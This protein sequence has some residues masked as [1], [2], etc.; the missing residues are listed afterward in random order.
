MRKI[1]TNLVEVFVFWSLCALVAGGL[2]RR[3]FLFDLASHFRV[4]AI[5][6]LL[7]GG[8]LLTRFKRP[9]WARVGLIAGTLGTLTLLPYLVPARVNSA[10]PI[11]P[12]RVMT[13]NVLTSNTEY[14]Q[15]IQTIR[16][17]SPDILVLLETSR[18]W[19]E[20]LEA[21]LSADWPYHISRPANDNFGI[22]LFSR[23]PWTVCEIDSHSEATDVDS[24]DARF[25]ELGLRV[26][27]THPLPPMNTVFWQD[28]AAVFDSIAKSITNSTEGA[29]LKTVVVGDLNCTP[30]SPCFTR[31]LAQSGLRD[32][33]RGRGIAPTWSPLFLWM[34]LPIDHAL[35]S[36]NVEV[37]R[38]IVGG[39]IG[40]DHRPV[41]IDIQ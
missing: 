31:F 1:F 29:T 36:D 16:R 8:L 13:M 39:D 9:F 14:E 24:I 7:L 19:V 4:H 30:W 10:T 15:A 20:Q 5:A 27:G 38:R 23:T 33:A 3:H 26:I 17:F 37:I 28:R 41:V 18:P 25:E 6:T 2:G 35:V 34:G 22:S 40:S 32:S 11:G 21:G 12:I